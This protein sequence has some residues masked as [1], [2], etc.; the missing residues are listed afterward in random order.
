[1]RLILPI[2]AVALG[3]IL[4]GAATAYPDGGSI[5][6]SY[7]FRGI[8]GVAPDARNA[9][10]VLQYWDEPRAEYSEV[11]L[12]EVLGCYP[13][14]LLLDERIDFLMPDRWPR[15]LLSIP[16]GDMAYP[17]FRFDRYH[18]H[19]AYWDLT[20]LPGW[21]SAK[22]VP[23]ADDVQPTYWIHVGVHGRSGWYD[24]FGRGLKAV[25]AAELVVDKALIELDERY[26]G[27]AAGYDG[28]DGRHYGLRVVDL[29]SDT[30][31]RVDFGFVVDGLTG[32]VVACGEALG[33][34]L[35]VD[36]SRGDAEAAGF[37]LPRSTEPQECEGAMDL[38]RIGALR[39]GG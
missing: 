30:S 9:G 7:P 2:A 5:S 12:G 37:V 11:K 4:G 3:T 13:A 29:G 22:F 21:L 8:I 27:L 6:P 24:L 35:L 16:W 23:V 18:D 28:S 17:S 38:R 25:N 10:Y 34:P 26:G 15:A 32:V 31:C 39:G 33:G 19:L 1:M 36:H 14:P 20:E